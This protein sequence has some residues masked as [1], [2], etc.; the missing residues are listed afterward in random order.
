MPKYVLIVNF[1]PGI[2]DTWSRG[3]RASNEGLPLGTAS[4]ASSSTGF[5]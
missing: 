3:R 2:A 5:A 1:Q 4:W